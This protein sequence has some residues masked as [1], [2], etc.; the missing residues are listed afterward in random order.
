MVNNVLQWFS[1]EQTNCSKIGGH[2]FNLQKLHTCVLRI[3]EF[4]GNQYPVATFRTIEGMNFRFPCFPL[5]LLYNA[6]ACIHSS[7]CA[8]RSRL[9]SLTII[10]KMLNHVIQSITN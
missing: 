2:I 9:E 5:K 7:I 8:R 10:E 3:Y 1:F 6:Q 4:I